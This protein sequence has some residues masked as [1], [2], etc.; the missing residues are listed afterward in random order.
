MN[1]TGRLPHKSTDWLLG[2]Q[3]AAYADA[4]KHYL[5]ERRYASSSVDVYV[6][7]IAKF[8]L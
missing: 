8:G 2:S 4:F 7:C 1:P 3:P 6:A 5:T